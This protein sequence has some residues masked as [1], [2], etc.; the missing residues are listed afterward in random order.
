MVEYWLGSSDLGSGLDWIGLDWIG[1]SQVLVCKGAFC[2]VSELLLLYYHFLNFWRGG[3]DGHRANWD[4]LVMG[5]MERGFICGGCR[6]CEQAT[7]V[8]VLRVSM[9]DEQGIQGGGEYNLARGDKGKSG[10]M[11][12]LGDSV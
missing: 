2:G 6:K 11:S 8:E 10:M 12:W 3:G 1:G 5:W 4:W 7:V 9:Y